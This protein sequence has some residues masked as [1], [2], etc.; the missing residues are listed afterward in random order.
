MRMVVWE[1]VQLALAITMTYS[2]ASQSCGILTFHQHGSLDVQLFNDTFITERS[3]SDKAACLGWC[4]HDLQC[5]M[6][7]HNPASQLCRLYYS[8]VITGGEQEAGWQYYT[9]T[10]S[11]F[12]ILNAL[13]VIRNQTHEDVSC[14]NGFSYLPTTSGKCF[15]DNVPLDIGRC[16]QT[17]CIDPV[18]VFRTPLP[19][20]LS[21]GAEIIVEAAA[22]GVNFPSIYLLARD[23]SKV[24]FV[25]TARWSPYTAIYNTAGAS[26]TWGA[27][28]RSSNPVL[29]PHVTSVLYIK[30]TET[31][32]LISDDD[33]SL[34]EVPGRFPLQEAVTLQVD[35]TVIKRVQIKYP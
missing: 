5:N 6:V 2:S 3:V 21:S 35:F 30:M 18:R 14:S 15:H 27:E 20:A 13:S 10:C 25:L 33:E 34:L 24:V 31:Q 23:E 32:F 17:L 19:A 16:M 26:L 4:F 28:V 1:F 7:L 8:S 11:D 12:R 9:V 29:T 22:D